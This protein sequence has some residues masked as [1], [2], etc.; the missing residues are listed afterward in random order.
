MIFIAFTTFMFAFSSVLHYLARLDVEKSAI[1]V[2][3]V[4]LC[5]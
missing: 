5:L 4:E 3:S 1:S 2:N